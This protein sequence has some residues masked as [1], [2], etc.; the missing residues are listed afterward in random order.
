M[1]LI[2]LVVSAVTLLIGLGTYAAF[3]DEF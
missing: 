2:T 3:Y 1:S